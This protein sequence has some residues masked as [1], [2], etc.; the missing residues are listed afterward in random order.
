MHQQVRKTRSK[1]AKPS[2]E[3]K[4][5]LP[6]I[7]EE[8]FPE[9]EEQEAPQPLHQPEMRTV[10]E[11]PEEGLT[12]AAA[13]PQAQQPGDIPEQDERQSAES[14]REGVTD[15]ADD[16]VLDLSQAIEPPLEIAEESEQLNDGALQEEAGD[17]KP[18]DSLVQTPLGPQITSLIKGKASTQRRGASSVRPK[19]RISIPPGSSIAERRYGASSGDLVCKC[20]H[21]CRPLEWIS[22]AK[23]QRIALQ[24]AV[25]LCIALFGHFQEFVHCTPR[26]HTVRSVT[27]ALTVESLWSLE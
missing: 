1:K 2:E 19:A 13:S 9:A 18:S 11:T 10:P 27:F 7:K 24:S 17:E 20:L 4:C 6:V 22:I 5:E 25:L 14:A 26:K 8:P 15:A 3:P 21:T 16:I 23:T 12:E